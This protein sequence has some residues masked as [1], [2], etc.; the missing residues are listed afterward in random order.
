MLLNEW[1]MLNVTGLAANDTVDVDSVSTTELWLRVPFASG[2]M[3][4][5]SGGG[6]GAVYLSMLPVDSLSYAQATDAANGGFVGYGWR[7]AAGGGQYHYVELASMPTAASTSAAATQCLGASIAAAA[8][9]AYLE[10]RPGITVGGTLLT[11]VVGTPV[12]L[13][14]RL[15]YR[16]AP[17]V[18]IPGATALW[19]DVVRTS[20]GEEIA[21]PLASG[22]QFAWYLKT[23]SGV[24]TTTAPAVL[25]SIAGFAITLNGVSERVAEGAA[26]P[27]SANVSTSVYFRNRMD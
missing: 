12:Y 15:R 7:D 22:S 3:C 1:R 26:A 6:P 19:R 11:P 27:A 23:N 5:N 24:A 21:A 18:A 20:A 25:A 13:Y 9:G 4:A 17:S 8:N 16:F 14:Q 10:I 2:L